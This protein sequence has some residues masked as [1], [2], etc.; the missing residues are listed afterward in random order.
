M[1]TVIDIIQGIQQAAANAYDGA[2]DEGMSAD[3]EARKTGLK[4]EQGDLNLEARV[5]DGFNVKFYGNK[6]CIEY[7]GEC[8]L[9]ETNDRNKFESDIEQMLA[10]ISSYLKKEY[11][12]VTGESQSLTKEDDPTILVSHMNRIRTWVQAKQFYKV[13]GL[14]EVLGSK[15]LP[16]ED[17]LDNAIKDWLKLGKG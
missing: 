12:K 1:A 15:E 2:H 3:G 11:K 7:H 14:D 17:R 16:S 4:R 5:M 8:S 10:D 6:I 13:G 9:K